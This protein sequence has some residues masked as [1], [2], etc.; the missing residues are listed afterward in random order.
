MTY[1]EQERLAV[2][3]TKLEQVKADIKEIRQHQTENHQ[4]LATKIEKLIQ[5]IDGKLSNHESRISQVEETTAPFTKFRKRLWAT[6]VFAT[7]SI[8]TTTIILLE[9]KRNQ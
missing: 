9:I 2:L 4:E 3:E 5:H 8:A 1:K 6:I 7:L